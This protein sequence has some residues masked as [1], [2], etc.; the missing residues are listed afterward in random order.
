MGARPGG[1]P[2]SAWGAEGSFGCK[3][4][5]PDAGDAIKHNNTQGMQNNG[6]NR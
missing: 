3:P 4:F 2:L 6:E 1:R 5:L